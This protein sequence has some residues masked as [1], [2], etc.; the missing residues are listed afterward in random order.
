MEISTNTVSFIPR[1]VAQTMDVPSDT[2]LISVVHSDQ[3]LPVHSDQ[4]SDVHWVVFDDIT[5]PTGGLVLF[6][7]EH[8]KLITEIVESATRNDKNIMVHCEAGMS[9][10]AGIAKWISDNYDYSLMIHPDG[11]GTDRFHNDHVYGTLDAYIGK[12]LAAYYRNLEMNSFLNPDSD[13]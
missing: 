2:V 3:E 13:W 10:S 12:N 7:N 8:A 5:Q 6:T 1:V 11:I 9:R 4:W